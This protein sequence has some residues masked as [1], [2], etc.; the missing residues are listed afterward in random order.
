MPRGDP[1]DRGD[2]EPLADSVR[3]AGGRGG[4]AGVKRL[5]SHLGR[6]H[7]GPGAAE[8]GDTQDGTAAQGPGIL[9]GG[10]INRREVSAGSAPDY[11]AGSQSTPDTGDSMC[12]AFTDLGSRCRNIAGCDGL[13]S[14]HS[15]R[16]RS[17]NVIVDPL[18]LVDWTRGVEVLGA[19]RPRADEPALAAGG[20]MEESMAE[21]ETPHPAPDQPAGTT[22]GSVGDGSAAA[23]RMVR[24]LRAVPETGAADGEVVRRDGPLEP[25][26]LALDRRRALYRE[27]LPDVSE[28]KLDRYVELY[29]NR[30][31]GETVRAYE[32]RLRGFFEYAAGNGFHPLTCTSVQV[33]G[34]ILHK[35]DEGKPDGSLYSVSYFK[36]FLAALR[37]ALRANGLPDD[38]ASVEIDGLISGYIRQYGSELPRMA[39]VEIRANELVEIERNVRLGCTYP[40]ALL[41]AAVALGCDAGLGLSVTQLRALT[42][43]DVA[44]SDASAIV[45]VSNRGS[46]DAIE[47]AERRRDPACP[48]AALRSL[49]EAARNRMRA[50]RDGATPTDAQLRDQPVF[51]NQRSA[52]ALSRKGLKLIVNKA[53]ASLQGVA[54]ASRGRLPALSPDQRRQ[55]IAA[56][57]GTKAARNLALIFHTAFASA[58]V[59]NVADFSVEHVAI[60]GRDA[61]GAS[62]TTPIVDRVEPD[63]TVTKGIL[64]R[65][66]AI[67]DTDILDEDGNSLIKSKLILGV[68]NTFAYGTKTK[69]YHENWYVVQP[70]WCCCPVRLLL[71]W[72]RDYDRLLSARGSRLA[73]HHPLFTNL[74]HVGEPIKYLSRTLGT[75]VKE[76]V[77]SIGLPP[78]E[79]S[80]H[81]LRKFR[82]S[83]VFS[84][85]G[86]MTNVMVHDARSSEVEGLVYARPDRRDPFAA[87]PTVGIFD[88][89][90]SGQDT[91]TRKAHRKPPAALPAAHTEPPD[92]ADTAPPDPAYT[93]P[94][95]ADTEPPDP[96]YTEPDPADTEPPDPAYTEPVERCCSPQGAAPMLTTAISALRG[97]VEQLRRAGLDDRAITAVAGLAIA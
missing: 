20:E 71:C 89:V 1:R 88:K 52:A 18:E 32:Q 67:T 30:W 5:R 19:V 91:A 68:H 93:E 83:W 22:D 36:Q 54:P 6:A 40:A 64:S 8:A 25:D 16:E 80:A 26:V 10:G 53:C 31:A 44:F 34:Y 74:K 21:V 35:M 39:K 27:A 29:R 50:E 2:P 90:A 57:A 69:P 97:T 96:A 66:A 3:S 63:G 37:R 38:T 48:V 76:A 56:G 15:R 7:G 12:S 79:Y 47:I 42:F 45:V 58:R 75:I 41:R 24:H 28:Q 81:S 55:V 65:I 82:A 62:I 70:G 11:S 59:G 33:E 14:Y 49:R 13:C 23:Q 4:G 9:P 85:G 72:L 43:E 78:G 94:D 17:A 46:T 92:P 61:D 51:A 87:D 60:W 95:P 77:A 73:G 84:Q 86:S